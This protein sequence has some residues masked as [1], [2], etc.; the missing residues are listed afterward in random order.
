MLRSLRCSILNIKG[1]TLLE[2]MVALTIFA[3]IA[4][5]LSQTESQSID[6]VLYLQH[7]T[8]AAMLAE[9]QLN[10][11][12]LKGLPRTGES[13]QQVRFAQRQWQVTQQVEK[14]N[15][16]DTFRVTLS[17]ALLEKKDNPLATLAT[18]MGKH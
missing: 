18:I 10:E 1:F 16:P 8:L 14:T 6:N 9:N 2:V 17:V 5:T 11:Q 12:R 7:K 3:G 15:F 13:H 4:L